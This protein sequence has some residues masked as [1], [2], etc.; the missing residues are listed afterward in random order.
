MSR[1][2]PELPL[3]RAVVVID[4]AQDVSSDVLKEVLRVS[5]VTANHPA[6]LQVVLVGRPSLDA[7]LERADLRQW[8]DRFPIR[9]HSLLPM[10]ENEIKQDI[11]RRLWRARGGTAALSHAVRTPRL[12][13]AA[14]RAIARASRGNPRLVIR[15]R[16]A[17][18]PREAERT[19]TGSSERTASS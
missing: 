16:Q 3:T 8:L 18:V 13:R 4:D 14:A 15:L 2:P 19:L 17:S 1:L 6:P 7:V 12:T 10:A 9:R 5:S 11:E